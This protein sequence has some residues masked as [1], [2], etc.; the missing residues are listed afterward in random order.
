MVISRAASRF[1]KFEFD[2][3]L[4]SM[5]TRAAQTQGSKIIEIMSFEGSREGPSG[6]TIPSIGSLIRALVHAL[7]TTIG[8]H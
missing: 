2:T 7:L 5:F 8:F 3:M 1:K 4:V 6:V